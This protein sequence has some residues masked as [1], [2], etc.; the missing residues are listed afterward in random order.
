MLRAAVQSS[1]A[2][3]TTNGPLAVEI[4]KVCTAQTTEGLTIRAYVGATGLACGRSH[5]VW[6]WPDQEAY[7]GK[8][9]VANENLANYF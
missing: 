5:A 1:I 7:G 2:P 6:P 9:W 8:L 3:K 4:L